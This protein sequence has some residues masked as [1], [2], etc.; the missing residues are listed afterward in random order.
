[1]PLAERAIPRAALGRL[2]AKHLRVLGVFVGRD[3]LTSVEGRLGPARRFRVTPGEGAPLALCYRATEPGDGTAVVF[4]AGAM[5]SWETITAIVVADAQDLGEAAV[6]CGRSR[7]VTKKSATTD[8]GLRLGT[9]KDSLNH[10]I[11]GTPTYQT[12]ERIDYHYATS[13]EGV[14]ADH[15]SGVFVG[16]SE[17]HVVWFQVYSIESF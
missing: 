10:L 5:G 13:G 15:L 11:G 17:S 16:C 7:V 6:Y 1:M 2:D 14:R 4:E 8:G 9:R 12:D 3:E